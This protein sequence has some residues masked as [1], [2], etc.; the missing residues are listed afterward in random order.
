MAFP[1]AGNRFAALASDGSHLADDSVV[2]FAFYNVGINEKE[3]SGA[4]FKKNQK[5]ERFKTDIKAIFNG[6]VE[7]QA[8]FICEFG[9][10]HKNSLENS[11]NTRFIF[12]ELLRDIDLSHLVIKAL[13]PYVAIVD[14]NHW[15][16]LD[17]FKCGNLC[18]E[19]SNFAMMLSL[20]HTLS[21]VK[22]GVAN[23]H[24]PSSTGTPKR[25]TD[26][27]GTLCTELATMNN[28][29]GWI[30]GGDCNLDENTMKRICF[31]HLEPD[32]P[33]ISNSGAS[34]NGEKKADFAITRGLD[35]QEVRSWVGYN[36]GPHASD[37]HNMVPVIG[38]VRSSAFLPVHE[39]ETQAVV[40]TALPRSDSLHFAAY[41]AGA[42]VVPQAFV[43]SAPQMLSPQL[44]AAASNTVL[45]AAEVAPSQ[46]ATAARTVLPAAE[47]APS[48]PATAAS[49]GSLVAAYE[50]GGSVTLQPQPE[51]AHEAVNQVVAPTAL[52]ELLQTL[53]DL[54][55]NDNE[56]A[57]D[58]VDTI[59]SCPDR[60]A[61]KSPEEILTL[62]DDVAQRRKAYI[63]IV[64]LSRGVAP[65][66]WREWG[67]YTPD[68]WRVWLQ[69][70]SFQKDDMG[71][72]IKKWKEEFRLQDFQQGEKVAQW[73]KENTRESKTKARDL[74]NGAWKK[75][76]SDAY[77]PRGRQ[78][79]LAFL[80]CPPSN[81]HTLL[82]QWE[83]YLKSPEYK[84]E[85]QRA[86]EGKN[87]LRNQSEIVA[88]VKV[89]TLRHKR[90]QCTKLERNLADSTITQVPYSQQG[91]YESYLD[92]SLDKELD[93]ATFVHGYGTLSTGQQIGAFGPNF[94]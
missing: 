31:P 46:S 35:L 3:L 8:L 36:F 59:I 6:P 32:V 7:I 52:W 29:S 51:P 61:V 5:R 80:K 69:E 90:R 56:T 66:Q 85:R 27:I 47:V 43:S 34:R 67:E 38:T 76:L 49:D 4:T 83:E 48:Q 87:C 37:Q 19:Q 81:V 28:L 53:G 57:S 79:A 70:N 14:P 33:C 64:S 89:H 88:T 20:E 78:L 84:T 41:E 9:M 50:A 23:C 86:H 74:V 11:W 40:S 26:T 65:D 17:C 39:D 10:M 63:E 55:D 75:S 25:R 13:P 45:P 16:V 15:D 58:L 21:G 18:T 68:Q 91:L 1:A 92:G 22:I 73:L 72:A 71:E 62:F 54:A 77:G 94:H 2:A 82:W 93:E 12:E 30:I 24:I 44:V 42:D 60:R